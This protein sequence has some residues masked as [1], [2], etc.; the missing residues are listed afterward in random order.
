MSQLTAGEVVTFT[1]DGVS[2]TA[3][4]EDASK[5]DVFSAK[6]QTTTP[7]SEVY[8][9]DGVYEFNRNIL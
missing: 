7:P 9:V 2:I 6:V 5:G 1:V 4:I 8:R 3:K